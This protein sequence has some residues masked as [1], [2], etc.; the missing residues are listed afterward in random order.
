MQYRKSGHTGLTVSEIGL[1]C[2]GVIDKS[3]EYTKEVFGY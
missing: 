3:W 2:K 1:G